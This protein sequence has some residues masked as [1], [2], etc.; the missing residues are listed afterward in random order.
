ML[1]CVNKMK[2]SH[3]MLIV[4]AEELTLPFPGERQIVLQPK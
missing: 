4:L 1:N 3:T 2:H